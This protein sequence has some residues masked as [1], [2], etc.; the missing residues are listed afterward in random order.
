MALFKNKKKAEPVV[1][2]SEVEQGAAPLPELPESP[3][4]ILIA[5]VEKVLENQKVIV[6]NQ[7]VIFD[8]VTKVGQLMIDLAEDAPVPEAEPTQEEVEAA[9]KAARAEKRG[10]A[11]T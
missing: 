5:K 2:Y 4:E 1:A 11:R 9:I 3:M 10:V 8:A 6:A 7:Q